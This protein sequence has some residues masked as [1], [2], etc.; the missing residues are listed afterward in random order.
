[1]GDALFWAGVRP[2][3]VLLALVLVVAGAPFW[4]AVPIFLMLYNAAHVLTRT[5]GFRM[6]L[7]HG[8]GVAAGLR[9]SVLLRAVGA[10]ASIGAF[11]LGALSLLVAAGLLTEN[12]ALLTTIA[13][14]AALGVGLAVGSMIRFPAVVALGLL[15]IA[16]LLRG[17]LS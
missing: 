2:A 8:A 15:L 6:G 1:V 12:S 5:W 14:M 17:A 9:E 13:A 7:K 4:L 11:L 16:G 10:A 3:S